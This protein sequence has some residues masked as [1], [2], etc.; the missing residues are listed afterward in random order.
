MCAS[1]GGWGVSDVYVHLLMCVHMSMG[2]GGGLLLDVL[3]WYMLVYMIWF[4][5]CVQFVYVCMYICAIVRT[6]R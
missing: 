5:I 3:V 4:G 2:E 6:V 1:L